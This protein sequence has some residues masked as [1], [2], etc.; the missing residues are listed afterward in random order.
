[1]SLKETD[2][3]QDALFALVYE[4]LDSITG[5]IFNSEDYNNR[6]KES[7]KVRQKLL[8][9]LGENRELLNQYDNELSQMNSYANKV[10]YLMALDDGLEFRNNL[11]PLKMNFYSQTGLTLK[12]ASKEN[13]TDDK[14]PNL[15]KNKI[16]IKQVLDIQLETLLRLSASAEKLRVVAGSLLSDNLYSKERAAEVILEVMA[17]LIK[18]NQVLAEDFLKEAI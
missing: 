10:I 15:E 16:L 2:S 11:N 9:I 5:N 13:V 7:E 12:M 8:E 18:D 3:Y 4:R 14:F 17:E 6:F 1:M